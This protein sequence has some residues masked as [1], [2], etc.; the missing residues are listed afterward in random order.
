[1]PSKITLAA[2]L[3]L[4]AAALAQVSA[5]PFP[6]ADDYVPLRRCGN[7]IKDGD[8]LS[9]QGT[10]AR[11]IIGV[12]TNSDAPAQVF[13]DGTFLYIRL[14]TDDPA[15]TGTTCDPG[16]NW[17]HFGWGCQISTCETPCPHNADTEYEYMVYIDGKTETIR[18]NANTEN[19]SVN[20]GDDAETPVTTYTGT[21]FCDMTQIADAGDGFW[22][23]DF[24]VPLEDMGLDATNSIQL[25]CGSSSNAEPRLTTG[26]SADIVGSTSSSVVWSSG[27]SDP[28]PL[29]CTT[30][31]CPDG[32]V[33]QPDG[34]CGCTDDT[35]CP[36][37]EEPLCLEDNVCHECDP[38]DG[39]SVC[40]NPEPICNDGTCEPCTGA[41]H[42]DG[43][44]D[45]DVVTGT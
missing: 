41:W 19:D 12:A 10:N 42:A 28:I 7:I 8:D 15:R 34:T 14:R 27:A 2:V 36:T 13:S 20:T 9:G 30:F 43:D 16:A 24:A 29:G 3:L 40:A 1:M 22:F 25:I 44:Y 23:V 38:A 11:D 17:G 18:V 39:N 37:E 45:C 33:C 26:G 31:G 21:E 32:G 6:D 35:D 5:E 4:P